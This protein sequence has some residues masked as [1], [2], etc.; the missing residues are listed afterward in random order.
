MKSLVKKV[1]FLFC[2]L[3]M[4]F[5]LQAKAENA[6]GNLPAELAEVQFYFL[7]DADT[8]EILLSKNPDVRIAPSSMTKIMTAYVVFDQIKK[9]RITFE[10]QCLIGKDAWRKSGSSM[11]L[12]YGDVVSIEDLVR[13]LLAVSGNDAAVALAESTAGGFS[14]FVDLMNSKARELGLKNS[15][16]RNPHGLNEEG[17]YMSVRDLATLAIAL[18]DQFPQYS[19]YFGITEFTYRNITQHSRNPLI[20]GN[21][22]GVVGG[23]TGHTNEGGYGVIGM[24]KRDNRRLIGVVNKAKTPKQRSAAIIEMFDYGFDNYKKITLFEKGQNVESLKTWLG[25]KSKVKV[26]TNNEVSFNLPREK[27]VDAIKVSVKYKAPLHTPISKGAQVANLLVE[28]PGYKSFEYPLITEEKIDKAGYF[29]R[30]RQ[31]LRYKITNFLN[32]IS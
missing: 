26:I 5:A 18:Q 4:F 32:K 10:N 30:I 3:L 24:V 2:L 14:N 1:Y 8:K 15:H 7:I 23:K 22:D 9:G 25:S 21:Y 31:I 28:I 16:F 11:F 13:G 17:H 20:K 29:E 27:A 12:N 19:H 6:V